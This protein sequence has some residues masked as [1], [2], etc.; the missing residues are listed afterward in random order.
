[1]ANT[2]SIVTTITKTVTKEKTPNEAESTS[3]VNILDFREEHYEDI[4]PVMDKFCRLSPKPDKE[5]TYSRGRPY[6]WDSSLSSDYPRSR[7]RSHSIEESY[8]NTYPSYRIGDKH[9]EGGHLK[10]KSKRRKPIDEEDLVVPWSCEE[11]KKYVKVPVEIHKIIQK[12]KETIEDFL[13]RFKVETGRI[14]GT[15]ECMGIFRFMH[16]VNN[17]ELTKRLNKHVPKIVEEMMTTT[18]A[19]ILGETTAASKKKDQPNDGKGSN[20][21]THLT[22]TP[23]EIFVAESGKFKPPSPM[24]ISIEKRS[25]NKFYEFHKDEGH[26]IDECM[27]LRKQIEELVRTS[28]L[29]HSIKEI[30][31][32]RDQQNTGKKDAPVKDKATTINMIQPWQR[33]TQQK[34]IPLSEKTEADPERPKAIQVDVQK[35]VEAGILQEVYYHDWL[36]CPVMAFSGDLSLGIHFPGDLSP[37]NVGRGML[38]MASFPGDNPQRNRRSHIFSSPEISA[39]FESGG[40]SGNDGCGDDEKGVDE[41]KDGHEDV[42]LNIDRDKRYRSFSERDQTPLGHGALNDAIR[43]LY[44]GQSKR[45]ALLVII[46]MVAEALRIRHIERLIVLNMHDERNPNFI[47][48]SKAISLENNWSDLSEQIQWSSP[49]TTKWILH[50]VGTIMNPRLRLVIAAESS[51]SRIVLTAAMD[52]N[53]SRKAWSAGNYTQ[54]TITYISG[55]L[56]MCLQANGANAHV[57]LANCVIDI[58][59]R[60]QWAIYGVRTIR[61][62]SDRTLC[63]TS[64]GHESVDIILFKCHGSEA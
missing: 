33:V 58:E 37:R 9:S 19:F 22:R 57:W 29:S 36:S 8:G 34:D 4:L 23:K 47:P 16:G 56:E 3:R 28:N 53:S 44:Y 48:D 42:K 50:N 45:S 10:S 7:D 20:K 18:K 25:S 63:V 40:A 43:N 61:L 52:N 27:Q 11:Q 39:T 6:K 54:P 21:F 5:D 38:A 24:V 35:Q 62:Y 12:D 64:D 15:P 1:M 49:K 2:T 51:T 17:L 41:D 30:R 59:P 31:R 32:D 55:F 26:S 60:Q 14:K 13:E 46:E